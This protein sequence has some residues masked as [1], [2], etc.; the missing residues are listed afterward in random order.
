MRLV[1]AVPLLLLSLGCRP[2]TDPPSPSRLAALQAG[3]ADARHAH[4]KRDAALLARGLDDTLFSVDAGVVTPSPRDSVRAMFGRYFAGAAYRAW[5][6]LEPPRVELASDGSVA[7]VIRTVCVDRE[8]PDSAGDRRRRVFV[9]ANTSTHRWRAGEWRMRTVTS[10]F[11]PRPPERCPGSAPDTSA[12]RVLA[13][14]ERALGTG[15]E[16]VRTL[17]A[18]A[19]VT[20]PRGRFEASVRSARDGRVRVALGPGFLAGVGAR[21]GWVAR[22]AVGAPALD[23]VTRSVLRG[24]ELHMLVLAPE[25]RWHDPLLLGTLPWL[26]DSAL[27]ISFLDDLAT[28]AT[29]YLSRRDTLPV[30]LRLVNQTGAGARRVDVTFGDWT[31]LDGVRL[32]RRATFLHGRDRYQYAYTS[33]ALNRVPDSAFDSR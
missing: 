4:F 33:L 15:A 9:V 25:T 1:Q 8:E 22:G 31:V 21:G 19:A 32:F 2:T 3:L 26:G 7:T 10:T 30:G 5:E 28:P 18:M 17:E 20:G 24:H 11:L 23:S 14:A 16:R 6:D 29:L 27:A 13:A 12:R